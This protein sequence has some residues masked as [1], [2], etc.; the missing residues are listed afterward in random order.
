VEIGDP[1]TAKFSAAAEMPGFFFAGI[2]PER[3]NGDVL[4]LEYL[5]N[6]KTDP[7]KIVVASDFGKYLFDY[8][9]REYE[10]DAW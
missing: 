6:V 10:R 2:I 7:G 1:A 5:N 4:R 8:I 9:R 3:N